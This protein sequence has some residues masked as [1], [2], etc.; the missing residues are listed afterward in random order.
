MRREGGGVR[1][2][3]VWREGMRSERVRSEGV[4]R[5]G[6]RVRSEGVGACLHVS[7]CYCFI[8]PPSPL[9]RRAPLSCMKS[10]LR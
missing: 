3:G 2:E 8:I 5:E 4:W 9:T 1:R 10:A 6:V 7:Y